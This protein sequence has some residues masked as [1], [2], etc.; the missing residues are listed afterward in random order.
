MNGNYNKEGAWTYIGEIGM[1]V[2]DYVIANEKTK[3][4]IKRVEKE[5]RS[6]HVPIKVELEGSDMQIRK[7][8]GKTKIIEKSNWREK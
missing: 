2:V 1:S 5:D 8:K 7:Q 4:N 6:D 3:E